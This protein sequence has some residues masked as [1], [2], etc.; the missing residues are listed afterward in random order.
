MGLTHLSR[1]TV[2]PSSAKGDSATCTAA[3]F[4]GKTGVTGTLAVTAG[5][6]QL[7]KWSQLQVYTGGGS[8]IAGRRAIVTG[9][10][11]V[12]TTKRIAASS[13]L[14]LTPSVNTAIVNAVC[15]EKRSAR[16]AATS[17]KVVLKTATGTTITGAV[18]WMIVGTTA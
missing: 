17:F 9:G 4:N 7:K 15:Y 6:V 10:S 12:V 11:A 3:Q 16:S 8:A 2:T 5:M 1:L 13:V 18:N 14:M